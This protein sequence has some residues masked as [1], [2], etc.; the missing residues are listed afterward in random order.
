[1]IRTLYSLLLTLALPLIAVRLW[2]RGR[3]QPGYRENVGERFGKFPPNAKQGAI[4]IHAVSVGETRAAK[5]LIDALKAR[6]PER[7][8]L[9]TGMTPAGRKTAYELFGGSVT[10][11]YLPYDL[12]TWQSRFIRHYRPALLLIM[13]TEIWPNMI[14]ACAAAKVP[15]LLVNARLSQRSLHRYQRLGPIAAMAKQALQS[16]HTVSAQSDADAERLTALGARN[17]VVSGN[18]KFDFAVDQHQAAVGHEWRAGVASRKVLLLASTR[19]GEEEDLLAAYRREFDAAH[20]I[21]TLLVLV[22]RHP[23]RFGQVWSALTGSGLRAARRS[24]S[25]AADNEVWLGDSMGEMSAYFAMCDVA[26]V[27][28]SFARLGGQNFIEGCALGKAVVVG[29]HTF[30]FSEATRLA[31]EAGAIQQVADASSALR[32]ARD[33]LDDDTRRTAMGEAGLR[34]ASAH[35]GATEKTMGLIIPLMAPS[36]SR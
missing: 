2:W 3:Q 28:G 34:F 18:V 24:Q 36:L 26:I 16:L 15:A 31:K 22:P 32:A 14:A 35:K 21:G 1:M 10:I 20:R 23:Q 4:W 27:G 19:E 12:F 25:P 7:P 5:P 17:V 30:N 29:P 6:F 11:S 33:L 9:L 8:L 13:E